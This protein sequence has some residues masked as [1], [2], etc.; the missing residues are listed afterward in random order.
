MSPSHQSQSRVCKF[1][2]GKDEEGV[3]VPTPGV[4]RPC[5]MPG[6][7]YQERVLREEMVA[8]LC[9]NNVL[10]LLDFEGSSFIRDFL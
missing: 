10:A 5:G 7:P 1:S 9:P 3:R 8:V 2:L 6:Q 4:P